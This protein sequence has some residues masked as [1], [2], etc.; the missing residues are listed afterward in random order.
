MTQSHKPKT[1]LGLHSSQG[2]SN[3]LGS[4]VSKSYFE[5]Y[6]VFQHLQPNPIIRLGPKYLR[7]VS[8]LVSLILGHFSSL[9]SNFRRGTYTGLN[10]AH[11]QNSTADL[12]LSCA[13]EKRS[14][15]RT[16]KHTKKM[17]NLHPTTNG[18]PHACEL[19]TVTLN[20]MVT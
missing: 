13:L 14:L 19:S 7:L 9:V 3:P 15:A 18:P 8:N 5:T 12:T 2:N 16:Q 10:S 6:F 4:R 11:L 17:S 20:A 1:G